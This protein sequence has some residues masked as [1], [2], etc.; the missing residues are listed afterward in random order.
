MASPKQLRAYVL[1]YEL[2]GLDLE[3]MKWTGEIT[4]LIAGAD[5]CIDK[6]LAVG[7]TCNVAIVAHEG[8]GA[9]PRPGSVLRCVGHEYQGKIVLFERE[10]SD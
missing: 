5:F 9:S 3:R 10:P 6:P 2:P 7:E 8:D 1:G 4:A